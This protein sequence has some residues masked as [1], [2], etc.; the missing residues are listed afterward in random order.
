LHPFHPG[1]PQEWTSGA[2]GSAMRG[3][4]VAVARGTHSLNTVRRIGGGFT[5]A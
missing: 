1:S 5:K 3:G 4:H 2:D